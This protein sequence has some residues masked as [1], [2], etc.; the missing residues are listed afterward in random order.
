MIRKIIRDQKFL[1]LAAEDAG[2]ADLPLARDLLETLQAHRD[3]CVGMAANMIGENKAIIAIA[4]E[5]KP[6][7]ML[8]PV[9][10]RQ[11]RPYETE[12]GCLSLAGV[13]KVTRYTS[14][15][16]QWQDMNFETH[17]HTFLDFPAQIIQHEMDHL[18]GILV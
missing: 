8:N 7:V 2:E 12:E 14:I 16:V 10:L 3:G 6:L 15:R 17:V 18:K 1:S 13:R 11:S 4:D 5:G 9:I